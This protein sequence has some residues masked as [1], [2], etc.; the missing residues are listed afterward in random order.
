MLTAYKKLMI[1]KPDMVAT[2]IFQAFTTRFSGYSTG[3]YNSFNL[4]YYTSD[5][6]V[7]KN[8]E[9]LKSIFGFRNIKILKQIHSA[10]II[11]LDNYDFAIEEG[12]G[13]FTSLNGVI[14]G[15][16]TAD[17]W[18]VQLIGESYVANLHCGWRGIFLGI[19]ENANELFCKHG[20]KVRTAHVG[21]GICGKCY[22]VGEE[23]VEK[24]SRISI[25]N[26]YFIKDGRYHLDLKEIIIEKLKNLDILNIEILNYCSFCKD[27]LY[28]YRRDN[29][30]T[31]RMLSMLGKL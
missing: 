31:G 8:Y 10:K 7:D 19:I 6:N 11:V 26:F 13:I 4:G 2:G 30:D 1:I 25:S 9:R 17:C 16:Q 5:E 27:Y 18:T 24:F 14:T 21:P 20:D 12:D 15:I 23:L 3:N 29:G 22:E 28:S